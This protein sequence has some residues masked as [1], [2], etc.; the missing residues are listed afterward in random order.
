MGTDR[1]W[2]YPLDSGHEEGR[3]LTG[4]KVEATDGII[5]H[6]DR[7]ADDTPQRHLVVDTGAWVFGRSLLIPAGQVRTVNVQNEVI[8]VRCTRAEAKGAPRFET[9][10]ETL[11]PGYLSDVGAYYAALPHESGAPG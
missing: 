11:D 7:Q 2:S 4:F 1:I 10:S 6:V 8:T 9:D 5:G 3:A